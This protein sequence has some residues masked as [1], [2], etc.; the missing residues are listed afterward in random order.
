MIV[1][2]LAA[3]LSFAAFVG[4]DVKR[5]VPFWAPA[6]GI[7]TLSI[8]REPSVVFLSLFILPTLIMG[9][10]CFFRRI[11]PTPFV[12]FALSDIV[13][14]IAFSIYQSKTALWTLPEVGGWGPAAG[15]AAAAAVLRLG[16]ATGV[17]D[18]RE[19]G[20]VS[21]GWWQGAMLAYWAGAPGVIVLVA[22]GIVLWA[23]AAYYSQ[24][25]MV[26]MTLAGGVLA[27][28]A[29]LEAGLF[30][31]MSVGLAGTALALGERTVSAWA[32]G[33][34][35]LSLITTLS[36]PTGE[37]IAAPAFLFPGAWAVMSA[38]LS[39]IKPPPERVPI[40]GGAAAVVAI[41][42]L[43]ALAEASIGEDVPV[44]SAMGGLPVPAVGAMWLLYGAIIA[45]S[46][47][48]SMTAGSRGLQPAARYAS[49]A[50]HSQF[51]DLVTKLLP[52]VGW[53]TFS[54][55]VLLTVRLFLAG[56]RTGF[57]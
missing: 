26:G 47:S 48:T 25:S 18:T 17:A 24:S 8:G 12:M 54:V 20:L 4:D 14:G 9:L 51:D 16:A 2:M 45:A 49:V 6:V 31:I 37:F 36:I 3:A 21:L 53:F 13:L 32:V 46:I 27:I 5:Q 33:I 28:A 35:P 10:A 19:G 42:Y 44:S 39:S 38:I 52:P 1:Y 34:L 41:S 29:G 43:G 7:I 23:M 55:A 15:I 56:F 11:S 22:G 30:G 50:R 57:L 40:L